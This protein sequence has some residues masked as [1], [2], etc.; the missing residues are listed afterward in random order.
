[1]PK[2]FIQLIPWKVQAGTDRPHSAGAQENFRS[3]VATH[4]S[5]LKEPDPVASRLATWLHELGRDRIDVS[6]A[7]SFQEFT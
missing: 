2:A 7:T 6:G 4:F 5:W 1:M 3:L